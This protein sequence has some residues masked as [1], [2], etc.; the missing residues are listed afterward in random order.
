LRITLTYRGVIPGNKRPPATIDKIRQN[1]HAQLERL[2][3]KDQLAILKEWLD[4]GFAA[5][6]PDFR[7]QL[8]ERTYLP[9]ASDKLSIRVRLTLLL[10]KGTNPHQ[11]A[12]AQGDIDNRQKA[13]IDALAAPPQLSTVPSGAPK[14]DTICLMSDDSLVEHVTIDVGPLLDEPDPKITLA[15][16]HADLVPGRRVLLKTLGIVT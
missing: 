10:L 4:S 16:I 9:I 1:F 11:S 15:I 2:W 6:A 14:R 5:G 8:G 12:V 3:G 7:K 13:L